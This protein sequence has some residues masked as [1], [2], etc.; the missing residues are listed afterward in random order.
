M[1]R[2]RFLTVPTE[3][4]EYAESIATHFNKRG[5][6]VKPE[7]YAVGYP[8]RPTLV[9]VRKATTVI[10]EVNA[11]LP[12]VALD[13][14]CRYAASC[15]ADTQVALCVP[16]VAS[17]S[18][19]DIE[20]LQ[21]S[22]IGLYVANSESCAERLAPADL[23]LSVDLPAIDYLPSKVRALLGPVYEQFER[24][25]WRD[26][27][28]D[29]CQVLEEQARRHVKAGIKST[30]IVVLDRN[31]NERKL[32]NRQIDRMT[33]GALAEAFS[34]I[35]TPNAVDDILAKSLATINRDRVAS[36]HHKARQSTERS[37]RRN[38]G[39]H[40]WTIISALKRMVKS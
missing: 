37:L 30:R 18:F 36:T 24:G 19:K 17:L 28:K 32:T 35:K 27:F 34:N 7:H 6:R 3:L 5:Y 40:M 21:Q 15:S 25:Q 10:V 38:V 26:A 14:W 2:P 12:R 4:L 16:D 31:G 33:L 11:R 13:E 8:E 39:Q 9:C 20:F 1:P 22:R 29:A 23:A